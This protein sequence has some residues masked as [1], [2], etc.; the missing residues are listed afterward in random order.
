MSYATL[1]PDVRETAE[2]VLTRKQLDVF[3]L[4]CAGAGTARIGIMLDVSEATARTHLRR[5]RQKITME[6]RKDANEPTAA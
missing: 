3:K 6:M 4:W 1:P 2:R 5:A